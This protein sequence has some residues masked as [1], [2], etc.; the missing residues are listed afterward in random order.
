LTISSIVFKHLNFTIMKKLILAAAM[1]I[2]FISFST[3]QQISASAT[4]AKKKAAK[5]VSTQTTKPVAQEQAVKKGAVSSPAV[6][7]TAAKPKEAS[8]AK[9]VSSAG[10][11]LKKDGTP[12]K[13]YSNSAAKGP[14]KK[15]GTPDMRYSKNK[16]G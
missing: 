11:V 13:R 12:D 8:A 1:M 7:K 2:G 9:N 14:V 16:K 3:A 10:V 6:A 5:E 15:D 4:N